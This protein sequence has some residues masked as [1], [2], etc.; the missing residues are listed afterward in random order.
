MR[1]HTKIEL[2]NVKTGEVQTYEDHN[3]VTNWMQ[4]AHQIQ[5]PWACDSFKHTK[6]VT[7]TGYSTEDTDSPRTPF[8]DFGGLLL[9]TEQ[10]DEDPDNY[11]PKGTV[12]MVGHASTDTYSGIDLT[13]GS[14]NDNLS[15]Y[16]IL[17]RTATMVWDF[18]LEQGN[19]EIGTVCLCNHADGKI[20]YGSKY[21][22]EDSNNAKA[23][24]Y[25]HA[26]TGGLTMQFRLWYNIDPSETRS[27]SYGAGFFPVYIGRDTNKAVFMMNCLANDNLVFAVADI[28]SAS[29]LP[30]DYIYRN[31]GTLYH[32]SNRG[33]TEFIE[34]PVNV[35]HGAYGSSSGTAYKP[36]GDQY[37]FTP[38]DRLMM[39][40]GLD[41][42]GNFWFSKD[43]Y[44]HNGSSTSSVSRMFNWTSGSTKTFVKVNLKTLETTEYS[45]TNTTGT[46]IRANQGYQSNYCGHLSDLC[47][48]ND[49][50][51]VRN[52]YGKLFAINLN[53]NAD[54]HQVMLDD[55]SEAAVILFTNTS[56]SE[57]ST[58]AYTSSGY[59]RGWV[60]DVLGDKIIFNTS[61]GLVYHYYNSSSASGQVFGDGNMYI[62]DTNTFTAKPLCAPQK[63]CC[64]PSPS[65]GSSTSVPNN[66][67]TGTYHLPCVTDS[68][69]RFVFQFYYYHS[70]S[71]TSFNSSTTWNTDQK[72]LYSYVNISNYGYPPLGL[73][74]I[75]RLS[76]PVVKTADMTMRITYTITA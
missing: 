67:N 35:S 75:N 5:F 36:L 50:M 17:D 15:T 53:N 19:G 46:I 13:R 66:Q 71:S 47:V 6:D 69:V 52:M 42:Q 70:S 1:G 34:I 11:Y 57:S 20:G 12:T 76:E 29:V 31:N 2:T 32:Y 7:I 16:N 40:S 23:P 59:R 37:Y 56:H 73:L 65:T 43:A 30:M 44:T 68:L 49:Y 74:T 55:E 62:L 21:Y 8:T 10:L 45:V 27:S 60:V 14:F 48:V 63:P 72:Y 41:Y 9:F 25:H 64:T 61:G 38:F 54:V 24:F 28:D 18:G 26:G 4:D 39:L 22:A 3:I 51:F 58:S 33:R